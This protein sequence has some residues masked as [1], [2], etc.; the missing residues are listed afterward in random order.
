MIY[1]FIDFSDLFNRQKMNNNGLSF[2]SF[3]FL[4]YEQTVRFCNNFQPKIREASSHGTPRACNSFTW[5]PHKLRASTHAY[6]D[7]SMGRRAS[8]WRTSAE[9][10]QGGKRR[11]RRRRNRRAVKG[12]RGRW[13]RFD[14][15]NLAYSAAWRGV[16]GSNDIF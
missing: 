1:N 2:I 4:F 5:L 13:S 9:K 11:T 8:R 16:T 12:Q 10:E 7:A 14:R 6:T 3:I 15:I